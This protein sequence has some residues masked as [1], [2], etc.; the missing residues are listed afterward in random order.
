[1]SQFH[2]EKA[3]SELDIMQMREVRNEVREFM[4]HN[5]DE[6]TEAQQQEWFKEEYEPGLDSRFVGFIALEDIRPLGYGLITR[7][8]GKWCVSGGFR[9]E[10]RGKGY[11][12]AMFSHLTDYAHDEL[13]AAEIWLDVWAFN[14]PA[15]KLYKKLGYRLAG[16]EMTQDGHLL[17]MKKRVEQEGEAA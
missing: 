3:T 11:G 12:E 1:M 13:G 5:Q 2:I 15:I 7:R 10:A 8:E 4:T 14:H 6:I 9:K 17:I 16:D